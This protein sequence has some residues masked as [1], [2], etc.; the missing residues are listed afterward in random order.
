MTHHIL[1]RVASVSSNTNAFGLYGAVLVS[2]TGLAIEL[3][4]NSLNLKPK[5]TF[6]RVP[7]SRRG[8][9]TQISLANAAA[10]VLHGEIQ[11]TL[12]KAPQAVADEI[13]NDFPTED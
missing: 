1:F 2:R 3:A 10:S 6:V 9:C 7:L 11:R 4:L 5:G 12:G 13:F 8:Q